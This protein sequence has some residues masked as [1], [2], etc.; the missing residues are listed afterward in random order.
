M[1]LFADLQLGRHVRRQQEEE[2][3]RHLANV[4]SN[5]L[6]LTLGS[7]TQVYID[8]RNFLNSFRE[9]STNTL[10]QGYVY[11]DGYQLTRTLFGGEIVV[12]RRTV[13]DY[14]KPRTFV[15]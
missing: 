4:V 3:A 2:R 14:D 12:Q 7:E 5:Y 9:F 6:D 1:G 11:L 10:A 13:H 8:R 15:L